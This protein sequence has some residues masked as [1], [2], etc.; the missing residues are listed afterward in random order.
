MGR[1]RTTN[2]ERTPLVGVKVTPELREEID[3]AVREHRKRT[4]D[5]YNLSRFIRDAI[6]EKLLREPKPKKLSPFAQAG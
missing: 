4:G 3:A 1:P 2:E 6:A 5:N